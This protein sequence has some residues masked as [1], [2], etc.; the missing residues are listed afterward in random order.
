M[1]K[2]TTANHSAIRTFL[3]TKS[4]EDLLT[5]FDWSEAPQGAQYWADRFNGTSKVTK[6][7]IA[8]IKGLLPSRPKATPVVTTTNQLSQIF[9]HIRER[10]YITQRDAYLDYGVQSFTRRIADL[11]ELGYKVQKESHRHPTTG[12]RYSRYSFETAAA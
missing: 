1:P 5:V 11:R 3:K 4:R 8:F 2:I 10:G 7:D 12:Q 6:E 9:N